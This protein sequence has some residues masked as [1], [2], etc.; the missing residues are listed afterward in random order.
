[1]MPLPH[2]LAS[3][4]LF[5]GLT[6]DQ[7]AWFAPLVREQAV[8]KGEYLFRLGEAARALFVVGSG[9]VQ[10]TMPLSL[11]GGDHE[12]VLEEAHPGAAIAWSALIEPH[13]F[14][15]SAR[16]GTNVELLG[17]APGDFR[18]A[19]DARP[20]LGLPIM[21]NLAGVIGHRLQVTQAMWTREFQRSVD[22]TFG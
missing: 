13:L 22:Q 2:V 10:L 12:V 4:S 7:C 8:R 14:T 9:V 18:R 20:D 17:F 19:L 1:M 11:K 6:A 3:S 16:A 15:M 21:A 5:R